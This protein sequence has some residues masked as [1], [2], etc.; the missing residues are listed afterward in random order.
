VRATVASLVLVVVVAVPVTLHARDVFAARCTERFDGATRIDVSHRTLTADEVG[1]VSPV[2]VVSIEGHRYEIDGSIAKSMG[3]AS[4][5]TAFRRQP[6]YSFFTIVADDRESL[7]ALVPLCTAATLEDRSWER[8]A[9]VGETSVRGDQ[10]VYRY[11]ASG[12]GPEWPLEATVRLLVLVSVDGHR[13]VL[14][15]GAVRIVGSD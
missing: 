2:S 4:V 6:V 10:R 14:D 12:S 7:E 9:I 3:W 13:Y 8:R 1:R 5:N 11:A 15:A